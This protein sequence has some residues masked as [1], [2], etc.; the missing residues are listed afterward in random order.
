MNGWNEFGGC[1]AAYL[2]LSIFGIVKIGWLEYEKW[3][4]ERMN[5]RKNDR[6]NER[7]KEQT[8]EQV[9]PNRMNM[10]II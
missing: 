2:I 6:K 9:I 3:K 8:N 1:F 10:D 7:K 4:N 5:D